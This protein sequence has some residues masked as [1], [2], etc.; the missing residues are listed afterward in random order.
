MNQAI[1][2][3]WTMLIAATGQ[4]EPM[5]PWEGVQKAFRNALPREAG[6][7][8]PFQMA[9]RFVAGMIAVVLVFYLVARYSQRGRTDTR[10]PAP[11]RFFSS[12]LSEL[13]IGSLD[14]LLLSRIAHHSEL[15]QPTV[16]LFSTELLRRYSEEWIDSLSIAPLKVFVRGRIK[17]IE[18]QA[19]STSQTPSAGA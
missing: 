19:F 18:A 7:L 9:L 13:G 5:A 10:H 14:R 6:E 4:A 12:V 16:I 15:A 8:S 2:R 1:L 17:A 3:V 11:G